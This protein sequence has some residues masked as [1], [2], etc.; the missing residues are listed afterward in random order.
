MRRKTANYTGCL[1][2]DTLKCLH[3]ES[4]IHYLPLF[5][6]SA[7]AD[8]HISEPGHRHA[9][10]LHHSIGEERTIVTDIP[11]TTRDSIYTRYNKF[12]KDFYL[13]D[14]AGIR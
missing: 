14:T 13:V 12:G 9:H 11:G 1:H 2:A 8:K 3:H 5:C 4:Q 10:R 6:Y 7:R